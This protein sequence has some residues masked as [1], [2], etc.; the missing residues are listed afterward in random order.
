MIFTHLITTH[1]FLPPVS[2][3]S[4]GG[5]LPQVFYINPSHPQSPT[6]LENFSFVELDLQILYA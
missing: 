3:S 1:G 6:G 5:F 4:L 2:F